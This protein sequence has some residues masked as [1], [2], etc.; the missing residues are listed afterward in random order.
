MAKLDGVKYVDIG[1]I[2]YEGDTYRKTDESPM[3]GDIACDDREYFLII[4][5]TTGT[6]RS[7]AYDEVSIERTGYEAFVTKR[8]GVYRKSARTIDV[9]AARR[10]QLAALTAE[11]TQ[12]EAQLVEESHLKI[13]DYA[14]VTDTSLVDDFNFGD[15]VLI[16]RIN[17]SSSTRY[18]LRGNCVVS[19]S[20]EW[21]SRSSLTKIT[22]AE[23]RAS[24]IAKIDAHFN[25]EG[26][27]ESRE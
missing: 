19:E 10:T 25:P 4:P 14:R 6:R 11:I 17:H 3:P 27:A 24:L 20:S 13:G 12:L 8:M 7:D 22:P 1:V 9:L 23:A 2:E 15:I 26:G 18:P 16:S 21:F 5:D